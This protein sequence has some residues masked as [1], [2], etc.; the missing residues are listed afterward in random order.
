MVHPP[1][2]NRVCSLSPRPWKKVEDRITPSGMLG[3]SCVVAGGQVD[4]VVDDLLEDMA[5]QGAAVDAAL[6]SA[7]NVYKIPSL[8]KAARH[9]APIRW[10]RR[11]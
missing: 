10:R 1:L 4:A 8:A 6:R 5:V 2:L 3:C 9:G 11:W 7:R